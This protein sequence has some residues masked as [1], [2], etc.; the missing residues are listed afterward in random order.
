MEFSIV[1]SYLGYAIPAVNC[2][3]SSGINACLEAARKNDA[4][5]IIQFSS[6]GSQVRICQV[7]ALPNALYLVSLK[8]GP[9]VFSLLPPSFT[10]ERHLTTTTTV[11]PLQVQYRVPFTFELWQNNMEFQSFSTRTTAPRN[12]S[13]GLMACWL[14]RN[15]T[16]KIM[17]NP[18]F[19]PT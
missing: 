8:V 16:F 5:I 12:S 2:V 14:H 6:G 4:P 3:T 17:A 1:S 11:L 7:D 13:P 15:A 10:V 19:H 9:Y 18:C